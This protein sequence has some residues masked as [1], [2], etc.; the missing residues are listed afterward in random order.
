MSGILTGAESMFGSG[1]QFCYVEC[2]KCGTLRL[3]DPPEDLAP[4]Y[5]R[6]YYSVV[7]EPEVTMGGRAARRAIRAIG[8]SALLGRGVVARAA[9]RFAPVRQVR[10]LAGIFLSISHCALPAEPRVLDVG[11]GSGALVYALSLSGFTHVVGIDPFAAADRSFDTGALLQARSLD[12]VEPSSCWDLIM[13]HHSFEH[14]ADPEATLRSAVD[15]LAAGGALLVRMP[16]VS[17]WARQHYGAS[18][19]QLDPP[20]HL[21]L[22]SRQ[23]MKS[24]AERCGLSVAA[25]L[26]DSTG[27]QFW[28]SE[29]LR[30][31]I[32]LMSSGS[33]MLHPRCSPF[34]A[35]ELLRWGRRSRRLNRQGQGDQAGWLLRPVDSQIP[36]AEHERGDW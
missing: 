28:G 34:T 20:R 29:Q 7:D 9:A 22:F 27:F 35:R 5:P 6:D 24:L 15:R 36:G 31:E 4:Y 13:F 14:L 25:V 32:P 30:C 26:D 1:E 2:G 3:E 23:G 17:S 11:A 12:D 19:V 33:H 18:W 21:V 10:T 8:R 16:T